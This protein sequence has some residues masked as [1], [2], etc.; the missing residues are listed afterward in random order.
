M[1]I[2]FPVRFFV[3]ST[4]TYVD[5]YLLVFMHRYLRT[6]NKRPTSSEEPASQPA[7]PVL[8]ESFLALF[9]YPLSSILYISSI[10]LALFAKLQILLRNVRFDMLLAALLCAA[11]L[12][13]A[14]Q[15][16]SVRPSVRPSAIYYGNSTCLLYTSPSPRDRQKSRMPSSA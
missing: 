7:R 10:N 12:I 16:P 9:N 4:S 14:L 1:S 13:G 2:T 5:R 11:K 8:S 15:N 6:S 3:R